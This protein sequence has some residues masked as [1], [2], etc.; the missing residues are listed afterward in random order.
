MKK[1]FDLLHSIPLNVF[2]KLEISALLLDLL[3]RARREFVD[4]LAQ[5]HAIL[6]D[7][8][9]VATREGFPGHSSNPVQDFLLLFLVPGLQFE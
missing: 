9:I 1:L 6:E 5:D 7:V 2:H 4:Q 8:L 3:D